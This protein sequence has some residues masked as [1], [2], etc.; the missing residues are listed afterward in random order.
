MTVAERIKRNKS[1]GDRSNVSETIRSV[2]KSKSA[3][4][5]SG[6][7]EKPS[8]RGKFKDG[9]DSDIGTG[10]S[11]SP[12]QDTIAVGDFKNESD[13]DIAD[14]DEPSGDTIKP[15]KPIA[16]LPLHDASTADATPESD[17]EV[18]L[19]S[20][21]Q[22]YQR[23][24]AQAMKLRIAVNN[25]TSALV[26]AELLRAD[27]PDVD[28]NDR[29]ACMAA[30]KEYRVRADKLIAK[31]LK[32]KPLDEADALTGEILKPIVFATRTATKDFERYEEA[33]EKL[34]VESLAGHRILEFVKTVRGFAVLSVATI[35]GE[36][37][38]LS[39]YSTPSKLWKRF[40]LAPYKGKMLSTWRK[41]G[42]LK[43]EEWTEVGYN[44]R[45]RSIAFIIG[46]NLQ[47]Q[48]DGKYKARI[49]EAKKRRA[50]K[51]PDMSKKQIDNHGMAMAT[52]LL[53]KDLW[54]AWNPKLVKSEEVLETERRNRS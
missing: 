34:M 40:G 38:N 19:C 35:I 52:K 8:A 21:L 4:V 24:R 23:R 51:Y 33:T 1:Y 18:L 30:L 39:N 36:A 2:G 41:F 32:G 50:E 27:P 44:P 22:E 29:K 9:G 43:A 20:R 25:G 10:M 6:E 45:R 17:S 12:I 47:M 13:A 3:R 15:V 46:K 31:L 14:R 49:I 53:L 37:G 28:Q 16:Q 54:K 5:R 26:A 7:T 48:N 11:D 42:G